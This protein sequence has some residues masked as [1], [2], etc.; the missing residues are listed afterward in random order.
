MT[1]IRKEFEAWCKD[2]GRVTDLDPN[3]GWDSP[4]TEMAWCGYRAAAESRDA[5]IAELEGA[6]DQIIN[7]AMGSSKPTNRNSWIIARAQS[8]LNGDDNYKT[9]RSPARRPQHGVVH[10]LKSKLDAADIKLAKIEKLVG[11]WRAW[12]KDPDHPIDGCQD[13]IRADEIFNR[14]ADELEQA[15]RGG[16]I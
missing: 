11:I 7:A 10:S 8:A 6:L 13:D 4:V 16:D 14:C 12:G 9:F 5:R 2:N 1:D 3:G 15:L